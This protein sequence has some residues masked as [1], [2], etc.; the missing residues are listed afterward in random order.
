MIKIIRAIY[1]GMSRLSVVMI[2]C[3]GGAYAAPQV[4]KYSFLSYTVLKPN[5][6]VGSLDKTNSSDSF[7][8]LLAVKWSYLL[9]DQ[10]GISSRPNGLADT[11]PVSLETRPLVYPNPFSLSDGAVLG[12]RLSRNADVEIRIFDIRANQ[13]FKQ[14]YDAGAYGGIGNTYNKLSINRSIFGGYDLPAGIYFFVISS[15]GRVI[16]KGKFAVVPK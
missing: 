10:L 12:Y 6:G 13:I 8:V 4:D 15:E 11:S 16:G 2:L 7:Y 3:S 1:I 9:D 5:V 14:R